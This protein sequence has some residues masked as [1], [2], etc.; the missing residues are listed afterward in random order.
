VTPAEHYEKATELL[1][2]VDA[3][4]VAPAQADFMLRSAHIHAMLSQTQS[5]GLPRP[6]PFRHDNRRPESRS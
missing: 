5:P 3:F 4:D 6:D 1:E 2:R